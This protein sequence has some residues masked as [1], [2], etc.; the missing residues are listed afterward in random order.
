[1]ALNKI[2]AGISRAIYA[3][4]LVF[5]AFYLVYN[6]GRYVLGFL[7]ALVSMVRHAMGIW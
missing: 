7:M 1:V 6:Y 3:G 2:T 4:L 5:A